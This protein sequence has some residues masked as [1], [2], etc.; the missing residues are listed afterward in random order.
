[1][2][3]NHYI[4]KRKIETIFIYPFVLL[5]RCIA[6]FK[7]LD[8]EYTIFFFF[9]FYHTGGAEKVHALITQ[10]VGNNNCIIF[11]T[12]KSSDTTFLNNFKQSNCVIKNISTYTDNK[13]LYFLNLIYRG[14]ITNYINHQ[15]TKPIV[16]N[17]QC[18]F[19]YKIS[20]WI[21][22]EIKQIELIH[23]FNSFSWIRV[24]FIPYYQQNITVSKQVINWHIEHYKKINF[25]E[26]LFDK[27]SFIETKIKLP[28]EPFKK[29]FDSNIKV[30]Y[31]G[32]GTP[33]KRVHLAAMIADKV[34]KLKLKIDFSFAGNV[35]EVVPINLQNNINFLGDITDEQKLADLYIQSHILLVTSSTESG[36]LVIL[37]AM[38]YGLAVITIDVGFAPNY[39]KQD[40][41]G[42]KISIE[43]NEKEIVNEMTEYLVTLFNDKNKL[44]KISENNIEIAKKYFGIEHFFDAYR[45]LFNK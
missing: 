5:G 13:W 17:G 23:S 27:F 33:D 8:K 31:V 25:P 41:N 14:I 42:Y 7:P 16:F 39:I 10:A 20:P 1:M 38:A 28:T 6:L 9:P 30:I 21:N 34:K 4:L 32:R 37:E 29:D 3:F 19:A 22:K 11:F 40:I 12:K 24:P 45:E 26:K 35:K 2:T 43:K 36:P 18:N 44:K 15:K